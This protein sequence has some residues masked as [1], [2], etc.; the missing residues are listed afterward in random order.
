MKRLLITLAFVT[1]SAFAGGTAYYITSRV[2][3]TGPDDWGVLQQS[4]LYENTYDIS[5]SRSPLADVSI[6]GD[7]QFAIDGSACPGVESCVAKVSFVSD[8]GGDYAA[9]IVGSSTPKFRVRGSSKAHPITAHVAGANYALV[10]VD[11]GD[12]TAT[13]TLSSTGETDL[14]GPTFDASTWNNVGTATVTT[15]T[16]G[17]LVPSG[18]SCMVTVAFSFN[19]DEGLSAYGYVLLQAYGNTRQ[20]PPAR[21]TLVLPPPAE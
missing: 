10:G 2:T 20:Q 11:N 16:C 14:I 3:I 15:S 6:S 9:T 18:T 5:A 7:P 21:V 8:V 13:F 4:A 19:T 17:D 12:A 1:G